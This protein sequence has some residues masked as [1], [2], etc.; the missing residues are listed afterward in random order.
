[1]VAGVRVELVE[2]AVDL[3]FSEDG[4]SPSFDHSSN[5]HQS[6]VL[7]TLKSTA[8]FP[9]LDA[10]SL[11]H[12]CVSLAP[13]PWFGVISVSLAPGQCLSLL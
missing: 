12:E 7:V 13:D 8:T 6:V 1:M 9:S 10:I 4:E 5:A 3:Y 2:E 11:L